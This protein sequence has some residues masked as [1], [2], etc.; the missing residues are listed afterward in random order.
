M[1]SSTAR[2]RRIRVVGVVGCVG[3]VL[4]DEISAMCSGIVGRYVTFVVDV[5]MVVVIGEMRRMPGAVQVEHRQAN[6][7]VERI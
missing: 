6:K 1:Q 5:S 3:V 2:T 7:E 4:V